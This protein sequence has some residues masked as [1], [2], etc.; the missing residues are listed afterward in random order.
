GRGPFK[1]I[2]ERD[3]PAVSAFRAA[4]YDYAFFGTEVDFNCGKHV[5]LCIRSGNAL[6]RRLGERE[7]ALLDTTPLGQA[8]PRLGINRPH[9]GTASLMLSPVDVVD[10]VA[11]RRGDAP[12]LVY[13]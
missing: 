11:R 2:V 5:D 12:V 1:R 7:W 9:D 4:G 8:R 13:S 3:N 10:E 6:E